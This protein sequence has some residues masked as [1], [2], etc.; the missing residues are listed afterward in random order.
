MSRWWLKTT[1]PNDTKSI[2][3]P[4]AYALSMMPRLNEKRGVQGYF[5][6]YP[7]EMYLSMLTADEQSGIAT[8]NKTWAP[9]L[10]KLASFPGVAKPI[11]QYYE[12]PS[13]IKWFDSIFG[14]LEPSEATS[15][16]TR[17]DTNTTLNDDLDILSQRLFRRSTAE[18]ETVTPKG[19][20]PMDSRLLGASHLS[21]PMLPYAL[22]DAM[23]NMESG[24]LR[25]H[26]TAGGAVMHSE[27]DIPVHPAWRKAY[28]HLIATGNGVPG[29]D[30]TALKRLAPDMGCYANEVS[31]MFFSFGNNK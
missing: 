18:L 24:M 11:H 7:N 5:F 2:Y 14:P 20:T 26:L 15:Q 23:P 10:E 19:I 30:A 28:V 16:T 13:F 6:I 29:P 3:E 12:Y 9:I 8:A 22:R 21:N 25:G 27:Q 4:A 17:F 1:N 31:F